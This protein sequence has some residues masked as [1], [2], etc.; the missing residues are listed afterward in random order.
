M[1][2]GTMEFEEG[3]PA[4]ILCEDLLVKV[5]TELANEAIITLQNEVKSGR[6][7]VDGNL[8]TANEITSEAERDLFVVTHI[9]S[10]SENMLKAYSEYI[11]K[12]ETE[13][14]K[15]NSEDVQ[16]IETSKKLMLAVQEI[17][18]LVGYRQVAEEWILEIEGIPTIK[19]P[20][21]LLG[22]TIRGIND[23]RFEV[24]KFILKRKSIKEAKIFSD[25]EY[26]M[27]QDALAI[28]EQNQT[29]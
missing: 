15:L 11:I 7:K 8:V 12:K 22:S 9:A 2:D 26:K 3:I 4:W 10:E 29:P 14:E 19:D 23:D 21:K 1:F 6:M 16:K 13:P 18:L 20:V 28:A 17:S 27:M 24:L 25:S 5:K